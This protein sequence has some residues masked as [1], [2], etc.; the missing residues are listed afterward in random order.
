MGGNHACA[1]LDDT[2]VRCW[3]A[4]GS[5]QLGDGTASSS[6]DPVEPQFAAGFGAV[7]G[8]VDIG[9]GLSATC[10]V[11]ADGGVD[12]WGDLNTFAFGVAVSPNA[13][14]IEA[15]SGVRHAALSA[16]D[17]SFACFLFQDG[18]VSCTGHDE[19]GQQGRGICQGDTSE[20]FCPLGPVAFP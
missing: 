15:L 3:G 14:G 8:A 12:C 17:S 9:C 13:V 5:G 2:S 4:N 6:A 16:D 18:G 10:A 19:F 1:I 20:A 11:L 7:T